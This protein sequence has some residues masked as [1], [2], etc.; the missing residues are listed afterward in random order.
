[1]AERDTRFGGNLETA[2]TRPRVANEARGWHR[3]S[4]Q[5]RLDSMN[6]GVFSAR[7]NDPS[8]NEIRNNYTR[9]S[10]DKPYSWLDTDWFGIAG[11]DF[12]KKRAPEYLAFFQ[13][14][15]DKNT[16]ARDPNYKI[17]LPEHEKLGKLSGYELPIPSGFYP[18]GN[19]SW[20][21]NEPSWGG[22]YMM[23]ILGGTG[24]IG[25]RKNINDENYNAYLNLL[26]ELNG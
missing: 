17:T 22:D 10:F 7:T 5:P 13:D 20:I 21:E 15:K 24:R 18:Y 1:M 16:M 12:A 6:S 9:T 2:N 19:L 11:A 23:D 3:M 25:F 26:W 4:N 8:V 14:I